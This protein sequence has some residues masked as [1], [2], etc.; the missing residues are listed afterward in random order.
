MY[1][2]PDGVWVFTREEFCRERFSYRP[3]EHVVF[4]GPTQRGKTSLGFDLMEYIVTPEFPAYIA[5]SKPEDKVTRV[6]A[7][8]LEFR[9]VSTWP[10]PQGVRQL[11]AGKPVGFVVHPKFGNIDT[12]PETTSD[13]IRAL[14]ADRYAAGAAKK[15]RG[16][17]VLQDTW[18]KANVQGLDKPMMT[19]SAMAGAMGLGCWIEV[20]KP[21]GGGKTVLMAY[22]NSEHVFISRD[23]VKSNQKYYNDIGGFEGRF[24]QET[25]A[26]LEPF[27]FL[28]CSRD[29]GT[30]C[31]VDKGERTITK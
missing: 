30:A 23:P 25:V 26:H 3:G 15:A 6:R 5:V 28:Y 1:K 27:Q 31:I 19:I 4:G 9:T 29:S 24:V 10:P 13:V 21:S 20:Q 11:F 7:E 22:G 16:I 12:D 14:L 8:E 2:R 17:I 18:T